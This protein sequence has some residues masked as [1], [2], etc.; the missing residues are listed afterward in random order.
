MI[1]LGGQTNPTKE[2]KDDRITGIGDEGCAYV[3]EGLQKA[4]VPN[5]HENLWLWH[6]DIG[7][8][9]AKALAALMAENTKVT[10]LN[11][12]YNSLGGDGVEVMANAMTGTT[13]LRVLN[14]ANNIITSRG[15]CAIA[16]LIRRGHKPLT[17]INL[18]H[19]ELDDTA[20][21]K[22]AEALTGNVT[23]KKLILDFNDKIGPDGAKGFCEMFSKNTHMMILSMLKM[24]WDVDTQDM[25]MDASKN[26]PA[27]L[28]RTEDSLPDDKDKEGNK[29]EPRPQ[30]L[31]VYGRNITGDALSEILVNS[32]GASPGRA[33]VSD[34]VGGGGRRKSSAGRRKQSKTP[35]SA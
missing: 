23:V 4:G 28:F 34:S 19:N 1:H 10:D 2:S 3:C 9:G 12:S 24:K 17:A 18:S 16:D 21:K 8:E 13:V 29:K 30:Q 15:G 11:L 5:V 31:K 25:V 26:S 14:L 35:D 27:T 6:N 7:R 20:A 22:I 33:S 32:G